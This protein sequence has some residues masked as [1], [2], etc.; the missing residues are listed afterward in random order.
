MNIKSIPENY[1]GAL[2]PVVFQ[3]WQADPENAITVQIITGQEEHIAGE[4]ILSGEDSYSVNVANYCKGEI[5]IEPITG[6]W[7]VIGNAMQRCCP[8][9]I[10][11][12]ET[13]STKIYVTGGQKV[14]PTKKILSD[15]PSK[16]R[17][18]PGD[19]DEI[20]IIAPETSISVKAKLN[21]ISDMAEIELANTTC[22]NGVYVV[23]IDT[24]HIETL[25]EKPLCEFTKMTV[26]IKEADNVLAKREYRIVP[27]TSDAVR[28]CWQNPYGQID[29]H[30]FNLVE[31]KFNVSKN[32][33]YL[34]SGYTTIGLTQ[35]VVTR[36]VSECEPSKTV[37]W[38]TEIMSAPQVWLV[39]QEKIVK[40]DILTDNTSF[41]NTQ[42]GNINLSFRNAAGGRNF[43][44]A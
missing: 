36:V 3:I 15:S 38:L 14:C 30:T 20:A 19:K 42:P 11:S 27:T 25:L 9:S 8:V 29:Y 40:I 33:I 21:N 32:K 17:I 18:S 1:T 13:S 31:E 26:E 16:H 43:I 34:S 2:A 7:S 39:A 4:K 6:E 10:K 24:E 23:S 5:N 22:S 37:K 35:E 28:L 12:G 41:S 44:K